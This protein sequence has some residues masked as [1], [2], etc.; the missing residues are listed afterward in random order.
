MDNP[1]F[2]PAKLRIGTADKL[3]DTPVAVAGQA[4]GGVDPAYRAKATQAAVKF[5]SF[6][7]SHMLHEM[8]ASTKVLAADDSP[9]KDKVNDDMLDLADNLV[10]DRMAG[11]RAFGIA[12]MILRQLLP[13][14]QNV[15]SSNTEGEN[16]TPPLNPPQ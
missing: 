15:Q 8:R 16:L 2:D 12:D 11:Q 3:D 9:Y 1:I 6:F 5:E 4:Q 13:A 10:A 7:I 14:G